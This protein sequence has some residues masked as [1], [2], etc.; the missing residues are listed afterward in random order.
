MITVKYTEDLLMT[1]KVGNLPIQKNMQSCTIFSLFYDLKMYFA[2]KIS[3]S[4][5]LFNNNIG[6]LKCIRD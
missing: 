1:G 6:N 4:C 5:N 2:Y 3:K